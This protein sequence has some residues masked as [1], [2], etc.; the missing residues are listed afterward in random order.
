MENLITSEMTIEEILSKF[1]HK[2]QKL[3]QEMASRGLQCVGCQASTW[4]TLQAGML[5]HGFGDQEIEELVERLNKVLQE[6]TDPNQISLTQKAAEKFREILEEEGKSGWGLRFGDRAGGCSGFEY[7]LDYSEKAAPDDKIFVSH[8]IEIHV[9]EKMA[10]RLM[11]CEIDYI[12][13]LNGSG[14]KISNPNAKGACGC[15]KSQSY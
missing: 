5:G 3:A 9:K 1:P 14:F 12:S 13:G 6:K 10:D 2:S 11:G 4:E 7:I 15:G 8:G